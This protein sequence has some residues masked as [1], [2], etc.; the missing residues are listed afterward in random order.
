MRI[1]PKWVFWGSVVFIF[2]GIGIAVASNAVFHRWPIDT[3]RVDFDDLLTSIGAVGIGVGA[4]M[5]GRAA[6]RRADE[7]HDKAIENGRAERELERR[8]EN[9]YIGLRERIQDLEGRS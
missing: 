7:A 4:F 8:E 5:Q 6:L 2:A 9:D 1:E 3:W